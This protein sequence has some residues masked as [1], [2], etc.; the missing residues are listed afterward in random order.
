MIQIGDKKI[1]GIYYKVGDE[2]KRLLVKSK[3]GNEIKDF[4]R[5]TIQKVEVFNFEESMSNI[6]SKT[7]ILDGLISIDEVIVDNGNIE[8]KIDGDKVTVT[9]S[10]GNS[11][12]EHNSK[13][14]NKIATSYT[15]SS[16]DSFSST[17]PYSNGGYTGTLNRDGSSY[18]YSGSYTRSDSKTV[19][20]KVSDTM[21]INFRT[22][23]PD[24][25]WNN[26]PSSSISYNEDGYSGTLNLVTYTTAD[27][28][29][30]PKDKNYMLADWTATYSGT[31]T[32]PSS[33]T[34]RWKQDYKGTV[35]KGGTD[36]YYKYKI[37]IKYTVKN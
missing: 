7:F 3:I 18:V 20:T 9:V 10:N 29:I 30:S 21:I 27:K 35:Y 5:Y 11:R 23:S 6:R 34:R 25:D 26:K 32:K 16:T 12:E 8:Y 19:T 28:R 17:K 2:I 15:T 22:M 24:T 4:I 13:K 33:D 37:N 1:K 14:Y 36:N 31:V